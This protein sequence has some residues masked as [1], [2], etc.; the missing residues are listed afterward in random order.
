MKNNL[1]ITALGILCLLLGAGVTYLAFP[2]E[3]V[4]E[5]EV[6][7]LVNVTVEKIVE[8]PV[9]V[10][11]EKIVEVDGNQKSIESTV[12]EFLREV[13][14]DDDLQV[15]DNETYDFDQIKVTKI[16]D[17]TVSVDKTRNGE[18]TTVELELRLKYTD[19]DTESKCYRTFNVSAEFEDGEDTVLDY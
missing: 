10:T 9:N 1:T 17:E 16:D 11:V 5:V 15:C 4:N 13:E 19:S 6:P 3:V 7:K 18:I 14:D 8:K 12:S 2:R